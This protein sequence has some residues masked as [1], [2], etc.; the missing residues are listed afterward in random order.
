[1]DH[2]Q[3]PTYETA[4]TRGYEGFHELTEKKFPFLNEDEIHRV[5]KSVM[6]CVKFKDHVGEFFIEFFANNYMYLLFG[7]VFRTL[8]NI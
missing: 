8:S 3:K 1:M 6:K 7:G 5:Y 4:N 2:V